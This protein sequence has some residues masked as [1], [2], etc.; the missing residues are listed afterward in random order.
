VSISHTKEGECVSACEVALR[1]SMALLAKTTAK[2][3]RR[4]RTPTY[5]H[6]VSVQVALLEA[7]NGDFLGDGWVSL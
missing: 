7:T 4:G 3:Q 5:S 2:W 6:L 1:D